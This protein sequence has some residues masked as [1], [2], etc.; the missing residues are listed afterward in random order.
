M[1]VGKTPGTTA[2]SSCGTAQHRAAGA[3]H[4][5]R[6]WPV[7]VVRICF[8]KNPSPRED[9]SSPR[10]QATP[11][12]RTDSA[13]E[14][15]CRRLE[16]S[17]SLRPPLKGKWEKKTNWRWA[18]TQTNNKSV[19]RTSPALN[20]PG[21]SGGQKKLGVML[22]FVVGVGNIRRLV[23]HFRMFVGRFGEIAINTKVSKKGRRNSLTWK[24]Y[25]CHGEVVFCNAYHAKRM[26]GAFT[27]LGILISMHVIV[28]S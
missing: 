14:C 25:T 20:V 28:F 11:S 13:V 18:R 19:G 2:S 5:T 8:F 21:P 7:Q 27:A 12:C 9:D 1:E 22:C 16:A 23:G 15:V 26:S 24:W 6:C 10:K 4:K 3:L 17:H